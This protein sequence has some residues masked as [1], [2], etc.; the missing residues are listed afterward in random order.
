VVKV[1]NLLPY[2]VENMRAGAAARPLDLDDFL[3]LVEM[4]A[5]APRLS[6]KGKNRQNVRPV[7][8]VAGPRPS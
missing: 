5:E 2:K 3:D 8:P 4:E 1:L 7:D 6:D